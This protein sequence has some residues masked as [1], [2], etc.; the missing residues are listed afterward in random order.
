[1]SELEHGDLASSRALRQ[2]HLHRHA[3]ACEQVV[4]LDVLTLGVGDGSG[5]AL[6]A[7]RAATVA[8]IDPDAGRS[9]AAEARLGGSPRL[10]FG[11]A[12]LEDLPFEA[13]RFGAVIAFDIDWPVDP[14]AA[15]LEIRRVLKA[16][17]FALLLGPAPASDGSDPFGMIVK[18]TFKHR[19]AMAQRIVAASAIGPAGRAVQPNAADYRGY[20]TA[21][22]AGLTAGV[23]RMDNP[24]H[25]V[26][27]VGER[28]LPR[29]DG[30][31]SVF[32]DPAEDL[33]TAARPMEAPSARNRAGGDADMS[34]V[35]ALV[36]PLLGA[37]VGSDLAS[38]ARAL[39][40]ANVRLAVQDVKLADT[41]R[42]HAALDAAEHEYRRL[43]ERLEESRSDAASARTLALENRTRA[44]QLAERLA[45]ATR[46]AD[47]RRQ[48]ID[49][50]HE[51][52]QTLALGLEQSRRETEAASALAGRL[53]EDLERAGRD[54]EAAQGVAE[55]LGRDLERSRADGD[56]SRDA[57]ARLEPELEAARREAL[58][59][60]TLADRL[61]EALNEAQGEADAARRLA[62]AVHAERDAAS[63]EAAAASALAQATKD[64][65]EALQGE[66][67]AAN[68]LAAA[69]E[70]L[71]LKKAEDAAQTLARYTE[72]Q[73]RNA[74]LQAG[75]DAALSAAAEAQDAWTEQNL[76]LEAATAEIE[77]ITAQAE[78]SR[79]E[80]DAVLAELEK[81]H[82]AVET[83]LAER[84]AVLSELERVRRET[85][86]AL[87]ERE[88]VSSELERVRDL[89]QSEQTN[90]AR[91]MLEA[92]TVQAERDALAAELDRV[93]AEA[94]AARTNAAAAARKALTQARQG[95]PGFAVGLRSRIQ[96][97]AVDEVSAYRAGFA[98]AATIRSARKELADQL[99][100]TAG[101]A[102]IL[103][104]APLPTQVRAGAARPASRK[105]RLKATFRGDRK[106]SAPAAPLEAVAVL[107]DPDHYVLVNA[108]KLRPGETPFDHY[109][110]RGRQ[111]GLSTHPMIDADWIRGVWP[112]AAERPFDLFAYINDARL[113][114]LWPNPL[115]EADHYRRMN[116]DVADLGVNPLAHYLLHGWREGRQPNQ[117]FDND[118]YLATHT[119]VLAAGANP[120]QHYL[121]HGAM[122]LRKP[123]PL[124]DHGFYLDRYPDV[125]SSGMDAY[126]H[127]IAYGRGEGR[128]SCARMLDMQ[129]LER[130]FSG[131]TINDLMTMEEPETR[132]RRLDDEFWPPRPAGEYWLP[133][134]LRDF[135]ID[136]FG[137]DQLQINAWLFSLIDRF[138]DTPEAF[139]ASPECERLI[140]RAR[141]LASTP[142]TG[143]PV[144]SIIIPVYN[145]LLYTLTCIVSVL[146]SAPSH[147]F[148]I[149]VGDDRS[150]DRTPE[151]IAAIGGLVRNV[152]H[153]K[154]LGFLGNCNA[155][156]RRAAGEYLV[157]LNNDTIVFPGW[158]D[159]LV[160]TLA[161]DRTIGFIGSKLLNGDGTLQEAGGIFWSDGSAWNFGRNAD[162]MAPEYNYLKDVDY[163]SG[164]S[165]ALPAELW[166]NL[167]GFDALYSPAYC[168]D[169][170]LAFRVRQAGYR[171]V[172][173][174]HS[175]LVHHEGRSHGR[176]VTSGIKA[177]QVINQEK[178]LDRWR[179][180]LKRE[181]FENA[182][183]VFVA[184]DRSA[185]KPHI[186]I[187]D[188]Y[189]PQWDRDAGSRTLYLYIKMFLDHGFAVTF[190][191]DNLNEDRIYTPPL[192]AMGVEVIYSAAYRNAF[193]RWYAE[194]AQYFDYAFLS[195]PHISENYIRTI[196]TLGHAKII[197]YGHDLHF[198]RLRAAFEVTKD[199]ALL[200]EAAKWEAVEIDVC[201][202]SNVVLYPG[203]EEVEEVRA[204]VPDSVSVLAFP[205]TIFN[206]EE[207]AAGLEA[208]ETGLS[209]DPY[210][211]MF[212]GGFSHDP[213]VG[214]IIWFV[215]EVMP[216][217]RR[218]DPRF[219][220]R[221]A[222]SNAPGEVT[223]LE[224][225]HV[226]VMGRITDDQL[227][228]LYD[229]SGL[230]VVP[231]LY[232]G[233]VKGKVIEAMARGVPVVM[234]SVGAQGIP[235]A[236]TLSYVE[237]DPERMAAAIIAS[238]ADRQ[239]ALQRARRALDFIDAH[240]STRAVKTL[241]APEIPELGDPF[242]EEDRP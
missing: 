63:S 100:Q 180:T 225:E 220:I 106:P 97:A 34:I 9:T 133:Q 30:T 136:R 132:L 104:P 33:W 155:V 46:E 159:S 12:S 71:A 17:G 237:D 191:A 197:Y 174:P 165:I 21:P 128:L 213:N 121:V 224:G 107:F 103:P 204:R 36:E 91:I 210:A 114:D 134:R 76:R 6:L 101:T 109:V 86:S 187:V 18:R 241:L 45:Q 27:V 179:E 26:W 185:R 113:H 116:R 35:A 230:A 236:E 88:A 240:Y 3:L 161:A 217:L 1:M 151:A 145:N 218:A 24:A 93:R 183:N 177:Y 129:R 164:A 123:H 31:D 20:T 202:L 105:A 233:G 212:V 122:E 223:A 50:S 173:H 135:I 37:P 7:T 190:W 67:D 205:I 10:T 58:D 70:A 28:A 201:R 228:A 56:A 131:A 229:R 111:Q 38:L 193:D 235:D 32:L 39:G 171:S 208:V 99:A 150:S 206:E 160:E 59:A 144:A 130:F 211:M 219:H 23:V 41:A 11:S 126:A 14:E 209:R 53:A 48:V 62:E 138:G 82:R 170:D 125:A 127:F 181:N 149:L 117:M 78:T 49:E 199:R 207:Q 16:D 234:T 203:H 22:G 152:R 169:S 95:D 89:H 216:H 73:S 75:L 57:L 221:I 15:L 147:S 176:D 198:K 215:R 157:F 120:L 172:Y 13:D 4:G 188:H 68:D 214:G 231:L 51:Q 142:I 143:R 119:D 69:A 194:N 242:A 189:V 146:E 182:Q 166:E 196:A 74:D 156:A 87:A 184:R 227:A 29:A 186:L 192:Q 232:G 79:V 153:P 239:D 61:N 72:T 158:L 115:F 84:Q 94:D 118:W 42:I 200:A 178:F 139:D 55:E 64:R 175:V 168:E 154:N 195:R 162:P 137:E 108:V 98:A 226:T 96:Q 47:A 90:V 102:G 2:L 112:D 124:F 77:R 44:E 167:E 52:I 65:L 54:L 80:R 148:E 163:V 43:A 40:Q 81:V 222:G 83:G 5:P 25:F 19:F 141:L 92:E 110:R 238:V 140:A 85:Q 66:L 8:S 60:R